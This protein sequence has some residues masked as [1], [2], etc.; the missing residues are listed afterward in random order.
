MY[1]GV[2]IRFL[3]D[4][5]CVQNGR[6]RRTMFERKLKIFKPEQRTEWNH[7]SR[8]SIIQEMNYLM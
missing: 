5:A 6:S 7:L 8:N 3:E 2:N 4:F 1:Q